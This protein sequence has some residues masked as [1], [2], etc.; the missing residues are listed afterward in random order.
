MRT[1]PL[2]FS[3][4]EDVF[5]QKVITGLGSFY[6]DRFPK[7]GDEVVIQLADGSGKVRMTRV[8]AVDEKA[9]T[10]DVEGGLDGSDQ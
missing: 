9:R 2:A 3:V 5:Q 1:F 4:T 7:I 8:C 6:L 10:F